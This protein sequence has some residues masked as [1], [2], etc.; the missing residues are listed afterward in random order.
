MLIYHYVHSLERVSVFEYLRIEEDGFR[1]AAVRKLPVGS[2]PPPVT[3]MGDDRLP[4][5]SAILLRELRLLLTPA[6]AQSLSLGGFNLDLSGYDTGTPVVVRV[7]RIPR[8][9]R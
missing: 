1:L 6:A 3:G 8:I 4:P 9:W 2:P 7:V 5:G